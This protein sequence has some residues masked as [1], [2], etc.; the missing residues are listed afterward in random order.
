MFS[1]WK[2]LGLAGNAMSAEKFR[3]LM[4]HHA[5]AVTVVAAGAPGHR[6]GLTATAFAPLSD[7][8]ATVLVCVQKTAGSHQVIQEAKAFSVNLLA[9]DQ[10]DV[11]DRFGGRHGV[12][13]DQRF[14]GA[15]WGTMKTGAPVLFDAIANLDCRLLDQHLFT[16]HSIFIGE[17][18]DGQVR[19]AAEPLLYFRSEYWDIAER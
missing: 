12:T 14:Q 8:P 10:R 17:V 18:V 4:R 2:K 1:L 13:G 16:T 6:A 7:N 5:S 11:A 9:S 15:L 19:E 3:D